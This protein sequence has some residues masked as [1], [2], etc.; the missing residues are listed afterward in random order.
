MYS[1]GKGGGVDARLSVLMTPRLSSST[2]R[3]RSSSR[4]GETSFPHYSG[5]L[6]MFLTAVLLAG[7]LVTGPLI[8]GAARLWVELPLLGAVALLLLIQ[9]LRLSRQPAEGAPRRMDAI[10][11][12]VALFVLYT[13]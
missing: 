1:A 8:L 4:H 7:I 12:A 13:I 11:W 5:G 2:R 6:G 3:R 10:D 9:G